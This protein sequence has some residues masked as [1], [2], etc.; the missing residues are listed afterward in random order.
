M[1]PL[2]TSL[3]M[4]WDLLRFSCSIQHSDETGDFVP[5]VGLSLPMNA[6]LDLEREVVRSKP[7]SNYG[8]YL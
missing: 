3:D 6:G 2:K 4:D 7:W 5:P 8:G 1:T